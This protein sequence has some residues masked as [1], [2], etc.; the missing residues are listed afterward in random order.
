[1]VKNL[2]TVFM[3]ITGGYGIRNIFRS[4]SFRILKSEKDLKIVIFAPFVDGKSIISDFPEAQGENIIHENLAIYKPNIVE[5]ILK[6][7]A[8]IVIFNANRPGTVE[9]KDKILKKR[10]HYKYLSRKI[11]K[12]IIGKDKN[13]IK[14][15]DNLD[16]IISRGKMKFYN[17]PFENYKP[18]LVFTTDFLHPYEWSIAK[19]AR[20]KKVHVI[21]MIANWDHFAKGILHKSDRVIVWNEFNKKQ[22]VD[23]YGYRPEDILVAGIPHQDYFVKSKDKFLPKKEFF[24]KIGATEDRK[25]ISYATARGSEDEQDIIEIICKAVKEGKI[26]YPSHVHV[27]IHPED[28]LARYDKLKEFGNIITFEIPK[29]TVSERFWSGKMAMVSAARPEIWVPD[30]EEMIHY[31]NLLACSDV[32]IN[33]ASSVT[34][35]AAALDIPIVNISFDGYAKRDFLE[36]NARIFMYTH[37]EFIPKSGGVKIAQNA[38]ELIAH[39]NAYLDDPKLDS[40]GRKKIVDEHCGPQDGK[41]GER[42]GNYIL[43]F[44]GLKR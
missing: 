30:D 37:Y 19:T 34:L 20:R 10:S 2:K 13:L 43:N 28:I 39:I 9:I 21:S 15:L 24:K 7:A 6:K 29:K 27:R 38:D 16:A 31:A 42:I 17:K 23:Y 18:D 12:K 1:M 22:L 3:T 14:A 5:R 26:K 4:D 41:C 40:D 44:L 11:V 36:S 25:L 35:D 8:E 33:V 32:A